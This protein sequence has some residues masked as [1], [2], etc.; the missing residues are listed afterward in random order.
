MSA[1]AGM[2]RKGEQNT[3]GEGYLKFGKLPKTQTMCNQS[4]MMYSR[5]LEKLVKESNAIFR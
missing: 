4:N 5:F 2:R 3:S 1:R